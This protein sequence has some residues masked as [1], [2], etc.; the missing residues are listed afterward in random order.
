MGQGP[1]SGPV[2]S[3]T[4]VDNDAHWVGAHPLCGALSQRRLLGPIK[5]AY[6]RTSAHFG[7]SAGQVCWH[8][9]GLFPDK[10]GDCF[11]SQ[12]LVLS[13]VVDISSHFSF[14]SLLSQLFDGHVV[15]C[16]ER[17]TSSCLTGR[18]PS[19]GTERR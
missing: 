1:K 17:H 5:P 19:S 13:L 15:N 8:P 12:L 2:A 14:I 16:Q 18:K 9:W 11:F 4:Y 6:H 7:A 3:S 10:L